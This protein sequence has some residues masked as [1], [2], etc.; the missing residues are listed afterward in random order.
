MFEISDTWRKTYPT[1]SLGVLAMGGVQNPEF[2]PALE[3]EKER[4][5]SELRA[6]FAG[7]D[8]KVLNALP[9]LQCYAAYLKP[10]NKNYHVFFQLESVALKGKPIPRVAALVEA[11]FMAE[12]EGQLLTAGH[13]LDRLE[14][15]ARL[16]IAAGSESYSLMNGQEQILKA[17]D[18]YIADR[19]GII[20]NIIYG[21]DQRTCINPQTTRV[22]F[23]TYAPP[24]IS[25]AQVADH[26]ERIQ[27]YV[28]LISP[29]A[30]PELKQVYE[31]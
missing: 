30:V 14:L 28:L 9:T 18:M 31:A 10:F 27:G 24:G 22:I 12:L 7:Q 25:P 1:A 16:E 2:C 3:T 6:R 23:T 15:P 29:K 21:P 17:G 19:Q 11:M 8:R 20:S 5:E 26:L 13:D 4:L